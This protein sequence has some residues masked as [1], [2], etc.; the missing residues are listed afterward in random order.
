[1]KN[2][3]SKT[4]K[5]IIDL[6]VIVSMIACYLSSDMEKGGH[7]EGIRREESFGQDFSWG[8][9]HSITSLVFTALILIH[10][11]Q[12][13]SM[14]K[15]IVLKNLYAKNIV[16]T[17]TIVTFI[18]TVISFLVYLTGFSHSRGEFH[19]TVANLFLITGSIHIVLNIKK[20]V[21]LFREKLVPRQSLQRV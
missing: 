17:I 7:R 2:L 6:F 18:I 21:A 13:W 5:G 14:I 10:V 1:M 11:I 12:H 9:V 15:G 8:T 16:T 3:S 19:G 20:F 4:A